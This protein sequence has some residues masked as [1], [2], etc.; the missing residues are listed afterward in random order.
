MPIYFVHDCILSVKLFDIEIFALLIDNVFLSAA[1]YR[2]LLQAAGDPNLNST[3]T[4]RLLEEKR[5]R[6]GREKVIDT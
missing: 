3:L 2:K 6:N 5:W 1:I 4:N